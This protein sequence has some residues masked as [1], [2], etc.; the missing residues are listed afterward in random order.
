M[1]SKALAFKLGHVT[2]KAMV[3]QSGVQDW[4]AEVHNH[5]QLCV[6]VDLNL[7]LKLYLHV[8]QLNEC[9]KK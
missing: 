1:K 8:V 6:H 3:S 9:E 2:C 4:D 5:V 7:W